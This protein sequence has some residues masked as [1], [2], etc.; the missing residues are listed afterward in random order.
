[1]LANYFVGHLVD[2]YIAL[3]I[4]PFHKW[5]LNLNNTYIFMRKISCSEA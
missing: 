5:C 4:D 3:C 1:M 2:L